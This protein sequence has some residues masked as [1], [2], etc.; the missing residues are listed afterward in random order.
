M[1]IARLLLVP[2][3]AVLLVFGVMAAGNAV[4]PKP[5]ATYRGVNAAT[6]HVTLTVNRAGTKVSGRVRDACGTITRFT[7]RRIRA[8]GKFTLV[9]NNTFGQPSYWVKGTFVTKRRATGTINSVVVCG[10]NA[11]RSYTARIVA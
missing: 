11:T 7:A 1:R 5:G 8:G 3:V 6:D 9:W 2:L 4:M 10:P